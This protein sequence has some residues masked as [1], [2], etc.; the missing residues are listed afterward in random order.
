MGIHKLSTLAASELE[1]EAKYRGK[2]W[3]YAPR[4]DQEIDRYGL[5]I[6]VANE[7]GYSPVPLFF[8]HADSYD[9][10]SEHADELNAARGL[11]SDVS[12]RIIASSMALQHRGGG[13]S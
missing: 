12:G 9:E 8:C 10:A 1:I 4:I 11:D 13:T 2:F 5:C 3:C 6:V 7:R